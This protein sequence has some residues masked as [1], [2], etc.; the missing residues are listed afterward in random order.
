MAALKLTEK[1][2]S[3]KPM[4][5]LTWG[6]FGKSLGA[7]DD[8]EKADLFEKAIELGPAQ[9]YALSDLS[10]LVAKTNPT[11]AIELLKRSLKLD[12]SADNYYRLAKLQDNQGG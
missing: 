9:S 1:D 11:E 2:V 5:Y 8:K 3:Y 7:I 12:P 6:Y 10:D 4:V